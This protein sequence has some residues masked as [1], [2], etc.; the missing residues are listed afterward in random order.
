MSAASTGIDPDPDPFAPDRV[1][2]APALLSAFNDRGVLAA[3]DVHVALTLGRL[4]GEAREPSLLAAALAVR[5]PRLGHVCADLATVRATVTADEDGAIDLEDLPW[6]A[7]GPWAE[8]VLD[9]PLTTV[10]NAPLRLV[11]S[12]LYLDRYWR[13][14]QRVLEALRHRAGVAAAGVDDRLLGAGLDRLFPVSATVPAAVPD[15]QREAARTAMRQRFTVIAG[16]P[17]TGKT[18]TVAKVLALLV[19][20]GD[21]GS[22]PPRIALAAPTG[23]AAA[24]LEESI[25]AAAP[26]LDTPEPVRALL[27][28]LEATTLHRLLRRHP[29]NS[30]RFRHDPGNPLPHDLVVVDE[31]SMVSLALMAKLLGAVRPDARIVMLG[32]PDQLYSVEAGAVLGDIVGGIEHGAVGPTGSARPPIA[33]SIVVLQRVHRFRSDSGIAALALAIRSGNGNAVAALLAAGRSDVTWVPVDAGAI[34]DSGVGV[35]A[36]R[37]AVVHTGA[38][39]L[40]AATAGDARQALDS[41]GGLRVLCAHRR[42]PAGVGDW[43][44][45]IERW[46]VGKVGAPALAAPWY[47]GRPVLVTR[48]DP[49]LGLSNGDVGVVV[50]RGDGRRPAVAFA[51]G[52]GVSWVSPA[53]LEAVQTVHAMTVHKSQGSQFDEVVVVLPEPS[54]PVLTRELLYTAVTRAQD[55]LTVI[56]SEASVRAAV[57]RRVP[58]A[59]GLRRQLWAEPGT[60]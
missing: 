38:A 57:G 26:I 13:H 10:R 6:P 30:S 23:K 48:N 7:T 24:R 54:S 37:E 22:A 9:S 20:Q 39:V 49:Q 55:R 58:R 4:V 8:A 50:A 34:D 59:S 60:T 32:D 41:L 29:G 51:D 36:V 47:V 5:A 44:P 53:R 2:D 43:V 12:L 18:T 33:D 27:A 46:L 35:P 31:T 11:G 56:G 14:E 19:E 1:Q 21:D 42:G 45:R 16:G 52:D 3:V 25:R 15:L 28:G 40:R 17:G